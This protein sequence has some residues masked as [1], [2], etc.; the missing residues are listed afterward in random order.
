MLQSRVATWNGFENTLQLRLQF[1]MVSKNLCSRCKKYN[2]GAIFF[3]TCVAMALRE[4]LKAAAGITYPLY[5]L[6]RNFFGLA[7]IAQSRAQFY[8]QQRLHEISFNPLQVAAR[9][10]NV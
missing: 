7:T 10:C 2:H 6:S 4:K 5:N 3:A 9:D 1:A 8:F